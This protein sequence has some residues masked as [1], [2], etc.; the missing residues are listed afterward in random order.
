M[1]NTLNTYKARAMA[2][3]SQN[4]IQMNNINSKQVTKTRQMTEAELE[5]IFGESGNP[6]N[7]KNISSDDGKEWLFARYILLDTIDKINLFVEC[8]DNCSRD[9]YV[10]N[11]KNTVLFPKNA[12][13]QPTAK[14]IE[15]LFNDQPVMIKYFTE[16]KDNDEKYLSR[17]FTG[18]PVKEIANEYKELDDEG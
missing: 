12:T 16:D 18:I 6:D 8:L 17:F 1:S 4:V 9:I 10:L 13:A 11:K 3:L 5:Q 7:I 15:G 2:E 14:L